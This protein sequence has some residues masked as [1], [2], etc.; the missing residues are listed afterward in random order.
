MDLLSDYMPPE[1]ELISLV[2]PAFL[3]GQIDRVQ[4]YLAYTDLRMEAHHENCNRYTVKS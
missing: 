4:A 1:V 2:E 3:A